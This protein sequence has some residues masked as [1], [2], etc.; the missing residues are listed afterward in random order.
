[1]LDP[2]DPANFTRKLAPRSFL[3]QEVVGDL[4]VPN[5]ATDREGALVGLTAMDAA[6]G[7]PN[8]APPPPMLP[9]P[10]ITTNPTASKFVKYTNIAPGTATCPPGNT[11]EHASL[12][13][14]APTPGGTTVGNDGSLGTARLQT[15]AITFLVLNR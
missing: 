2:A 4:V 1:M 7:V 13:R 14:P 12:L 9:S 11:F 3:I 15:D 6:C 8:S 10:A 5:I